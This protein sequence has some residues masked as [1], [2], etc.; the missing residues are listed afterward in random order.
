MPRSSRHKSHKQSKHGSRE[1]K[2]HSESEKEDVKK[3]KDRSSGE[4]SAIRDS[5]SSEK[6][7]LS[8]DSS[9]RDNGSPGEEFVGSKRRKE[10]ADGRWTGEEDGDAT[11][12]VK[13]VKGEILRIDG[14]N[15]LKDL[16]P[17]GDSKRIDG[18]K[19]KHVGDSKSKSSR[20][21]ESGSEKK[22]DNAGL[23]VEKDE[24]NSSVSRVESKRKSEKDLGPKEMQ[25]N[26]DSKD[27]EW[28]LE[29]EKK[30]IEESKR[31]KEASNVDVEAARKQGEE[32]QGKRSRENTGKTI[33]YRMTYEILS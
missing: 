15:K 17:V 8:K 29:R 23:P 2:E 6:R 7:K 19:S 16:K 12:A 25:Q 22:E 18:E 32:R 4:G 3:V 5:G 9:S 27:K 13:E 21:H 28:A 1:G 33:L 10:K 24:S 20:R 14:D 30:I 11:V 26:K 31:E